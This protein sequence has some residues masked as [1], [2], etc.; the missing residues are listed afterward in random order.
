MVDP[1][2]PAPR[3]ADGKPDFSGIWV[4]GNP[5]CGDKFNP[6]TYTCGVELPMGR[7]GINMGATLPGGGCRTSHGWRRS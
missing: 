3:T 2:A 7:D 1:S 6:V 5:V 4:T